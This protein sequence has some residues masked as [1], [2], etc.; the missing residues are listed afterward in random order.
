MILVLHFFSWKFFVFFVIVFFLLS[1]IP[2][3]AIVFPKN[4][5][6]SKAQESTAALFLSPDGSSGLVCSGVF[7]NPSWVLTAAHC[8]TEYDIRSIVPSASF[9]S[10][11]E[12]LYPSK[13]IFHDKYDSGTKLYDIALI[14]LSTPSK[15]VSFFP[16]L[17][18]NDSSLLNF[19]FLEFHGFGVNENGFSPT[20]VSSGS[21]SFSLSSGF[22]SLPYFNPDLLIPLVSQSSKTCIGD[23]GGPLLASFAS[24]TYIV[25]ISSFGS[26]DCTD[27]APMF[28]TRLSSFNDW[29]YSRVN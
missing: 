3:K 2:S 16:V 19:S 27:S 6:T 29:V 24:E 18:S 23:S 8:V 20:S 12:V 10:K 1:V 7:L 21:A 4:V 26:M 11:D 22:D 17:V 15:N 13:I 9:I 28:F 25:G 5:S 14:E